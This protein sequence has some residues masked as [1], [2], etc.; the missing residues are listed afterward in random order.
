[1]GR[2]VRKVTKDWVHPK[3]EDG[4]YQ[5]MWNEYYQNDLNEWIQGNKQWEDGT[6]QDLVEDPQRKDKYPCYAQWE[7]NPPS[8]EFYKTV[9]EKGEDLTH[10]Q[11]YET[12]SEGTPISPV[13]DTPEKLARW[14]ADTGASSFAGR[15]AL[16]D[17]WL[18]MINVGWSISAVSD[19][20]ELKSGVEAMGERK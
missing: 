7:G 18:H 20:G 3:R 16:Y 17:Q 1:M 8:V 15:T 19:G 9:R 14:L 4:S 6:H 10:F 11:M 5:P 2:E 12:V 13:F